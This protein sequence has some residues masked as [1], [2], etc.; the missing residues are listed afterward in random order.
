[1]FDNETEAR[2]LQASRAAI[3]ASRQAIAKSQAPPAEKA[4]PQTTFAE[5]T[6]TTPGEPLTDV[7]RRALLRAETQKLKACGMTYSEA[8]VTALEANPQW[9]GVEPGL[10]KCRA[11]AQVA[12][13]DSDRSANVEK[14]VAEYRS[15][16]PSASYQRAFTAIMNDP[17]N[18]KLVAAMHQPARAFKPIQMNRGAGGNTPPRSPAPK[19][20]A[21]PYGPGV[22]PNRVSEAVKGLI[23]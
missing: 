8:Y 4:T 1:M 12:N 17:A 7:Q 10:K 5:F 23:P 20:G 21:L 16:H 19:S 3:E 2:V 18:A 9:R 15:T 22:P 14:L 13:E 11:R 6:N